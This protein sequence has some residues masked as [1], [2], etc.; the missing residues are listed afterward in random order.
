MAISFIGGSITIGATLGT[1]S[2]PAISAVQLYNSGVRTNGWYYIKTNMMTSSVQVYCNQTDNGGGW[3]L[4]SYN[5]S[6]S[7]QQGYPYPNADSGSLQAPTFIKHYRNAENLWFNVSGSAQCNSVMRMASTASVAPLL[8]N[9]S[10]A[11]QTVYN[12][13]NALDISTTASPNTLKLS[14]PLTGSWTALKGYTF[15]TGSLPVAAPCDWLYDTANWWTTN[16]PTNVYPD[17]P[18]GRSGNAL[19][20]G[21]WT[22]RLSNNVYGM[23]GTVTTIQSA[24]STNFNTLAVYIK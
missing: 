21:G 4:V 9:C 19:G 1:I 2:N 10:I 8:S 15:M 16:G 23:L 18:H 5:P 12:N 3:M 7:T 22:N 11:H 17:A 20:T 14:A 13:P 24:Q 6:G